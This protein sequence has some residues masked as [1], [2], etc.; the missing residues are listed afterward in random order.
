MQPT[1]PYPVKI[2]LVKDGIGHTRLIEKYFRRAHITNEIITV[3]DGQEAV[4]YLFRERTYAEGDHDL[5]FLVLLDLN[6]PG[7]DGIQV[8]THL[9]ADER[10]QLTPVIILTA[11][12]TPEEM[13]RCYALGCEVYITKPFDC[14]HFI[15]AIRKLGLF[16]SV[17]QAPVEHE[18][19]A[20]V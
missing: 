14:E 10:T 3:H 1:H 15:E 7:L 13:E 11:V 4:D 5:P 12:D 2:V 8:L 6:L 17:V 16:L 18:R 20:I 9:R 19:H